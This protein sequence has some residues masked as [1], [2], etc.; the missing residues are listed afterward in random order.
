MPFSLLNYW[1]TKLGSHTLTDLLQKPETFPGLVDS[2]PQNNEQL[3]S[4]AFSGALQRLRISRK[5]TK[6]TVL[7]QHM[8][9]Q[10]HEW[11]MEFYMS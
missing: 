7:A 11:L 2:E 10:P 5:E 4:L 9:I 3:Q 8:D 6:H 1:F